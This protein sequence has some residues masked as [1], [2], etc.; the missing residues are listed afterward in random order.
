MTTVRVN[1]HACSDRVCTHY[2]V[3]DNYNESYI[4][5]NVGDII[6]VR[7][8]APGADIVSPWVK[9][10]HTWETEYDVTI[11]C[12]ERLLFLGSAPYDDDDVNYDDQSWFAIA[13]R[14]TTSSIVCLVD[15]TIRHVFTCTSLASNS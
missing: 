11:H 10:N 8:T 4:V 14:P 6:G 3:N 7:V 12:S 13:F 9:F 5:P 2:T 15:F 1:I